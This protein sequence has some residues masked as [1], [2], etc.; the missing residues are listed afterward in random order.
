MSTA[1]LHAGAAAVDIT[2][3]RPLFLVGYPHVPRT[4]T[5]VHDPLYASA[6]C[7]RNHGADVIL[8]AVDILFVTHETARRCRDRIT[9][10]TGVPAANILISATHTH[11]APVTFAYLSFRHDGVTPPP[12]PEYMAVFE[13]GIVRAAV[14]AWR[15]AAPARLAVTSARADGV[16]GNRLSPDGIADPE[17]G[18]LYV[19]RAG[20]GVP[21]ALSMVYA[22]H[23]TVLHEDSRL[24]SAD[25]PGYARQHLAA[26]FPGVTVLSHTGPAGNQSPRYHVSGQ[27][28]AEA[29][30][31]GRRLADAVARAVSGLGAADFT[32]QPVLD[33]RQRFVML[34]PRL[35]ST[36]REAEDRRRSA[37]ERYGRLQREGAPHGPLRTAECAV[38]GAEELVTLAEAQAAGELSALHRAEMPAEVQVLRIDDACWVGLRGEW[39]VEYGL[40]I[41]RLAPR[42]TF[43]ISLA[44]GELQGYIVTPEADRAG[45]YEAACSLYGPEAGVLMADAA[46][47]LIG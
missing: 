16:G 22:M 19:E 41:K 20:D 9:E 31:L 29:E 32:D 18:I 45:G 3:G 44:N 2:P 39:F 23:P 47:E 13:D 14:H 40:R 17:V 36:V 37:S 11:S 15:G 6:L 30:R 7:L 42:R 24:V 5:G 35:F 25:F 28:F 34:T 8:V 26:R 12:D 1:T 38:F 21:L 4:S 33:G 46:M 10:A 27:T 43:V